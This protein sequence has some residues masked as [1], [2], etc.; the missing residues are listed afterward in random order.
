VVL[1]V[2][3]SSTIPSDAEKVFG[4]SWWKPCVLLPLAKIF[5]GTGAV[6]EGVGD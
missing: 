3:A 4:T 1:P 6:D 2:Y 5:L